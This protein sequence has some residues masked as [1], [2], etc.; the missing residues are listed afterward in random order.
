MELMHFKKNVFRFVLKLLRKALFC[1]R[2]CS[3]NLSE[4]RKGL[5]EE[6]K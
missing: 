3:S 4:F 1:T 2:R 5:N 6:T